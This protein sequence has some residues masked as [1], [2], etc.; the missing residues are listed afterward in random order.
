[1]SAGV[2][3][4]STGLDRQGRGESAVTS[5]F[6]TTLTGTGSLGDIID[7]RVS[8]RS[9]G[10]VVPELAQVEGPMEGCRGSDYVGS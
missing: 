9:L 4:R 3:G 6:T 1:M 7:P 10:R 2:S 5:Q 8:N